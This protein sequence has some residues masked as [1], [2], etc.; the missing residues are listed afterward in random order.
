MPCC[1]CKKTEHGYSLRYPTNVVLKVYEAAP[2]NGNERHGLILLG[3]VVTPDNQL[4]QRISGDLANAARDL[5]D[6]QQGSGT[7]W[8][9]VLANAAKTRDGE[10]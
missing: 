8:F 3:E 4:A 9:D 6:W 2:E 7:E 5:K 1:Y 10:G